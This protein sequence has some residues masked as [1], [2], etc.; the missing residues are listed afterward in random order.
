MSIEGLSEIKFNVI[1]L[2]EE[3]T[4][5]WN[6]GIL[7]SSVSGLPSITNVNPSKMKTQ[8]MGTMLYNLMELRK[9]NE[10]DIECV[11]SLLK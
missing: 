1:S 5:L 7:A 4:N 10:D 3:I 9:I 2:L 8:G 11:V 6:Q